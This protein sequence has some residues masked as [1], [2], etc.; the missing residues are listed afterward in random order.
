MGHSRYTPN[1]V[2]TGS[3]ILILYVRKQILRMFVKMCKMN[4]RKSRVL[5]ITWSNGAPSV[6]GVGTG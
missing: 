3:H 2:R 4:I 5:V 1:M 6:V